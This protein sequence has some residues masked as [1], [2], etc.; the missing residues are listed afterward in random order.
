MVHPSVLRL[1]LPPT[2]AAPP[3][4]APPPAPFWWLLP[5]TWRAR[6]K[7][8]PNFVIPVAAG[9]GYYVLFVQAQDEHLL[10]TPLDA[11]KASP[12]TAT[13]SVVF[14]AYEELRA[15]TG[16]TLLRGEVFTET[17]PKVEAERYVAPAGEWNGGGRRGAAEGE[18]SSCGWGGGRGGRACAWH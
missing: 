16:L 4:A 17:C 9:R 2:L 13:P 18:G 5:Q 10:A 12:A 8:C 6:I 15:K 1:S 7:R 14:T 11:Y 3:G